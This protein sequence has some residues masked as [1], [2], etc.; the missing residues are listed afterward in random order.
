MIYIINGKKY[1]SVGAQYQEQPC[2]NFSMMPQPTEATDIKQVIAEVAA[3]N[4]LSKT[5]KQ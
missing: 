2:S 4:E 3:Q 5:K 1:Q